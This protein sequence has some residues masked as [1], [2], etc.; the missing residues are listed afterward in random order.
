MNFEGKVVLVTGSG[1]GIGAAIARAFAAEGASVAI[2]YLK[3]S[4]AADEVV[5]ACCTEVGDALAFKADVTVGEAVDDLVSNVL[6]NF[7]KIDVLVSGIGTG[8]T[9]TGISRYIKKK[10]AVKLF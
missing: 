1:R 5:T 8:G 2:N 4:E 10:V 9:I 3:N 6:E 7:G